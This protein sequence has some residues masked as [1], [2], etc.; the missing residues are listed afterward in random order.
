MTIDKEQLISLL[1]DKTGLKRD[2]VESQLSELISRIQQAAEAGKSFEIEGFGTFK[3]EDDTLSFD[4]S[5]KLETEINNRYAG[6]KPIELIGAFKEPEEGEIPDV[7]AGVKDDDDIWGIDEDIGETEEKD[8][9]AFP[10]YEPADEFEEEVEETGDDIFFDDEEKAEKLMEKDVV[11]EETVSGE[12]V[13]PVEEK[14][15]LAAS[16]KEGDDPIGRFLVIAV[17]VVVIGVGGWF[18]Y[19]LGLFGR[20]GSASTNSTASS[21]TTSIE[22]QQESTSENPQTESGNSEQQS[23][24]ENNEDTQP[25]E[26]EQEPESGNEVPTSAADEEQVQQETN[27]PEYGLYGTADANISSGYTIVVHSLRS[28]RQA[29]EMQEQLNKEGYRVVVAEAT[30]N[31]RTQYRVGVGQFETIPDAQ[32]AVSELPDNFK[33]NHFIKRI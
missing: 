14:K 18:A 30:V 7:G 33:N 32:D 19:D 29:A 25:Q 10:E 22:Q 28:K 24:D 17:I 3:M 1:V 27:E 13:S 11:T 4:P 16:S 20:T 2:Q 26:Q 15:E 23:V 9:V 31:G 5:D 8:E 12:S 21:P 6:M